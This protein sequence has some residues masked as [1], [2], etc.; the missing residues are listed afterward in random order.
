MNLNK[1]PAAYQ[2]ILPQS[3]DYDWDEAEADYEKA[4]SDL[5]LPSAG[6]LKTLQNIARE[7]KNEI[8]DLARA[9]QH[10]KPAGPPKEE[11]S[12]LLESYNFRYIKV[13]FMMPQETGGRRPQWESYMDIN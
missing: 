10:A 12:E 9:D 6:G 8:L 5:G 11:F 7:Q 3:P 2:N 13:E 1:Y 4:M